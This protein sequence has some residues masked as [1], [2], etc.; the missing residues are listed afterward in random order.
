MIFN[1]SFKGYYD[2]PKT[3][4]KREQSYTSTNRPQVKSRG[5]TTYKF[6]ISP[7]ICNSTSNS[8][9]DNLAGNFNGK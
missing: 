7:L 4:Y 1:E 3:Q 9:K 2:A 6:T 5:A 8:S